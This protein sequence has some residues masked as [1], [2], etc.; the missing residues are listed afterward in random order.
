[1]GRPSDDEELTERLAALEAA[2]RELR[3]EI[4]ERED[5]QD[6]TTPRPSEEL[7]RLADEAAL[8][9]LISVLKANIRMLEGLRRAIRESKADD[10]PEDAVDAIDSSTADR[11][12]SIL[13]ELQRAME[14]AP[15]NPAARDVLDQAKELRG[16]LDRHIREAKQYKE[17]LDSAIT[18]EADEE[19]ETIEID[20]DAE[21]EEIK[22]QHRD[23]NAVPDADTS[24]ED[25]ATVPDG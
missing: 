23:A 15:E 25:D 14:A 19:V 21:L 22:R 13:V 2:V 17:S 3:E 20:I 5:H 18:R 4:S 11:V 9:A 16:E 24:D 8:P 10:R 1:M 7:L 12:D 6:M